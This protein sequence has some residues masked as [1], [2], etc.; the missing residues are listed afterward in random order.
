MADPK[1]FTVLFEKALDEDIQS[2][3]EGRDWAHDPFRYAVDGR[4]MCQPT[5]PYAGEL[6]VILNRLY[7]ERTGE[8]SAAKK[9]SIRLPDHP[10]F[11]LTVA[12]LPTLTQSY[13]PEGVLN[14]S[15]V[16]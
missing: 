11:F 10:A 9:H 1:T 12:V 6:L 7:L 2:I 15:L 14:Q 16:E 5:F 8:A 13:Q 3:N 4:G